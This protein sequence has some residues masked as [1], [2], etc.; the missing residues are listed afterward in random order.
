M[1]SLLVFVALLGFIG[2]VQAC[3]FCSATGQTLLGEAKQSDLILFGELSNAKRDP[4]SFARGTT[5]LTIESVIKDHEFRKGREKL[6]IPR[7]I[8]K[9]PEPMKYLVFCEVFGGKLD[10]YR[11][12][13]VKPDSD[14]PKY[15]KGAIAVRDASDEKRMAYF[16]EYL[17]VDDTAIANDALTEFGN[18]DYKQTRELY[19][20]LDPE[21]IVKW[22]KGNP[23]A[24]RV[25]LYGHMLG[26]CGKAE[27]ADALK[28]L[29]DA[30]KGKR[31]FTGI[32][33]L[34]AGYVMLKPEEGWA[35]LREL[36]DDPEEEFLLRYAGLRALRFFW[37]YRQDLKPA[38]EIVDAACLLLDQSDIADLPIEDLRKWE[39]WQVADKVLPL[40]EEDSHDIPIVR[41]SILKYA[42]SMPKDDKA[43][44]DLLA[45]ARKADPERVQD[46]EE[47]LKFEKEARAASSEAGGGE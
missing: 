32:D 40:F 25:G 16:F 3:P 27:H 42:L 43:G 24:S 10:P 35:Y 26:H 34:L 17:N 8:P 45:K 1:R 36:L 9:D 28:N 41:R 6:S 23:P 38:K 13:A 4:G 7:Y 11:G 2:P 12:L 39:Q 33:G 29:L 19:Q 5:D 22:L 14:S 20:R 47:L 18:A 46:I 37:D 21:P 15:L 31:R 30:A 44:Q